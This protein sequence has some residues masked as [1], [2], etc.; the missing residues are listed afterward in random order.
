[1][2]MGYIGCDDDVRRMIREIEGVGRS[3]RLWLFAC[4]NEN[5]GNFGVNS[6]ESCGDYGVLRENPVTQLTKSEKDWNFIDCS[7]RKFSLSEELVSENELDE[8][9]FLLR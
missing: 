4:S 6:E 1:M 7:M 3:C 9:E 8:I 2:K 5:E